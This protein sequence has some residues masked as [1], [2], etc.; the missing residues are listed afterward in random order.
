MTVYTV[1]V[2]NPPPGAS[3]W[4]LMLHPSEGEPPLFALT[5]SIS[6]PITAFFPAPVPDFPL[7]TEAGLAHV[8]FDDAA[9]SEF[10]VPVVIGDPME[11]HL[12]DLGIVCFED[13][14]TGAVLE[15]DTGGPER[16]EYAA[17]VKRKRDERRQRPQE[18]AFAAAPEHRHEQHAK[19][20][21]QRAVED[22]HDRRRNRTAPEHCGTARKPQRRKQRERHAAQFRGAGPARQR[23][24]EHPAHDRHREPVHHF[25]RV[26]MRGHRRAVAERER[27]RPVKRARE[28]E[29][30]EAARPKRRVKRH[31]ALPMMCFITSLVPA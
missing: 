5:R 12:P 14:E 19:R 9:Q 20:G 4:T 15:F 18:Q 3:V 30:P 26:P 28:Q 11:E 6:D 16:R 21:Q 8:V 23:R 25:V 2:R 22:R 17:Y 27:K 7:S 10:M 31:N 29:R 13:F 1:A 24:E